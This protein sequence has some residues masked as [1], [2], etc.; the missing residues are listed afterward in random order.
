MALE[1]AAIAGLVTIVGN[2]AAFIAMAE[3]QLSLAGTIAKDTAAASAAIISWQG[4]LVPS[5]DVVQILNLLTVALGVIPQVGPYMFLV[6]S[7][8]VVVETIILLVAPPPATALVL[9]ATTL[10]PNT[11]ATVHNVS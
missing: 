8:I 11:P 6:Q 7:A 4:G 2:S 10:M 3:G 9:K 1:Q 5:A